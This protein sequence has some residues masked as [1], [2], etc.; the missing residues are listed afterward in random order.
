MLKL[1]A[2]H[3]VAACLYVYLLQAIINN[4]APLLFVTFH[5][6]YGLSLALIGAMITINFGIQL[7]VDLF[8]SKFADKIGYRP[9]IVAAHILAGAGLF[10]LLFF[11]KFSRRRRRGFSLL[12]LYTGSGEDLSKCS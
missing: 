7:L 11:R 1:K 8:A 9:L 2:G 10:S 12:R 5:S 6:T 4:F 3:T